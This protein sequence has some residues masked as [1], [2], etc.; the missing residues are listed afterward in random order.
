[1]WKNNRRF[2]RVLNTAADS[3]ALADAPVTRRDMLGYA[4][5][6]A[7]GVAAAAVATTRGA[8]AAPGYLRGLGDFRRVNFVNNRTGE[9][10]NI[11]YYADGEYIAEALDEISYLARD[12]RRDEVMPIDQRTLD[13]SAGMYKR[14][15]TEE[16]MQLISGYRSPATN[17]ML[18][19]KG[20]G[21]AKNS[22]HTRAMAFDVTLQSRSVNQM[23]R[24]AMSLAA[25]G[26]G[27]Y[28]RSHFVHLDCGPNRSWGR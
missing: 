2:K 13:M 19:R 5:V 10:L 15:E 12:W 16:P 22:F 23:Y 3:V 8:R 18:R 11:I 24:A 21:V 14:L 26:V 25:G 7:A 17:E 28:T 20:S 27:R 4:A 6:G 1:M 9:R